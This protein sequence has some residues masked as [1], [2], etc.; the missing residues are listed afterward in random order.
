LLSAVG[1]R[2]A[3][4]VVEAVVAWA[5]VDRHHPGRAGA[6]VEEVAEGGD[7]CP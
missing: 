3:D 2:A 4:D 7:D 6:L 5:V 1:N